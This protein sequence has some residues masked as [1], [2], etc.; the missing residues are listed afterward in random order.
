MGFGY[1][2][3]EGGMI[4]PCVSM[5]F[6]DLA[7]AQ[8]IYNLLLAWSNGNSNDDLG[9]IEASVVLINEGK[10][11]VFWIYPSLK[12]DD[13]ISNRIPMDQGK[14]Y[15][16]NPDLVPRH[17]HM[18]LFVGKEFP[19]SSGSFLPRFMRMYREDNIPNY[20]EYGLRKG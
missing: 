15:E 19:I 5:I 10:D 18:A 20:A 2:E 12:R 8:K 16:E 17:L 9:L 13:I 3:A 6:D 11:Y 14:F 7:Y 1:A 4:I